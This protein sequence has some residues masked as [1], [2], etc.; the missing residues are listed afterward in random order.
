MT[1]ILILFNLNLQLHYLHRSTFASLLTSRRQ[2]RRKYS[3]FSKRPTR[4]ATALWIFQSSLRQPS[5]CMGGITCGF[6]VYIQKL[7]IILKFFP[8]EGCAVLLS[9]T[10]HSTSYLPAEQ[11]KNPHYYHHHDVCLNPCM[12]QESVRHLLFGLLPPRP[13]NR[14]DCSP[15]GLPPADGPA[16][17]LPCED[18][19]RFHPSPSDLDPTGHVRCRV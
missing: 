8:A 5:E 10:C 1:E 14:R 4:T 6:M 17:C 2:R 19:W 18:L 13:C 12:H 9:S 15:H 3:N 11:P 7:P 16:G